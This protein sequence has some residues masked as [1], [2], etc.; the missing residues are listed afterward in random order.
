MSP[1]RI[2]GFLSIPASTR[3]RINQYAETPDIPRSAPRF[4][5]PEPGTEKLLWIHV[6]YTHTAWVSQILRRACYDRHNTELL[7]L[8]CSLA[9]LD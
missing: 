9:F 5:R 2:S 7:V 4:D 6:P 8:I 1:P 3:D